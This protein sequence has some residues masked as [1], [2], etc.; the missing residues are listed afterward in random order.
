MNTGGFVAFTGI[1]PIEHKHATVRTIT[2]GGAAE[3]SITGNKCVRA[4]VPNIAGPDALQNL[5]VC[6]P[7]MITDRKQVIALLTRQIIAQ[8]NHS[9]H[10]SVP[11]AVSVSGSVPRLR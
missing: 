4:M 10:V 2:E 11:P 5:L 6:P 7:A 8:V 9:A 3:P 1:T